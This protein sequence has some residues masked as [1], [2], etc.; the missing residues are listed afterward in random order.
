MKT[1]TIISIFALAV[2][3]TL[4]AKQSAPTISAGIRSFVRR[5]YGLLLR[6]RQM[7]LARKA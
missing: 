7:D 3:S 2:A 1:K 4:T 5:L 6:Q